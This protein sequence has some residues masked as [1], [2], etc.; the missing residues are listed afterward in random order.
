VSIPPAVLNRGYLWKVLALLIACQMIL[1]AGPFVDRVRAQL[2]YGTGAS[3]WSVG[4]ILTGVTTAF[5]LGCLPIIFLI[6][7]IDHELA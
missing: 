5:V 3:L 1:F 7:N 2:A 4:T 6:G